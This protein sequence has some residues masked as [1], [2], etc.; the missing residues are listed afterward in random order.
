MKNAEF[1]STLVNSY[2]S[3]LRRLSF[4]VRNEIIERLRN[5]MRSDSQNNEDELLQLFGSFHGEYS[6]EELISQI[7]SS[8]NFERPN[9]SL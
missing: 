1:N 3:L 8:R 2:L 7:R 5:S 6:A 9:P 4:N